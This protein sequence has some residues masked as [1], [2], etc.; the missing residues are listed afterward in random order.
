MVGLETIKGEDETT[1]DL[2]QLAYDLACLVPDPEIP[3]INLGDLG[4]VLG[5][6]FDEDR[7]VVVKL[8]PTYSGCPALQMIEEEVE[9][10]LSD[11]G[12]SCR[13]E[14]VISPAWT[15]DWISKKGRE[16]LRAYGIAP[17][18]KSTGVDL[19]LFE[20]ETPACPKCGSANTEL[21]SQFGSTP[22]KAHYNCQACFEPFDYFKCI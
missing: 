18:K 3:V 10:T 20:K 11:A 8:S 2:K 17:P 4:V 21:I 14:R 13:V 1:R 19:A 9:K 12:I 5:V 22:C 7:V 16:K 6:E 15:T